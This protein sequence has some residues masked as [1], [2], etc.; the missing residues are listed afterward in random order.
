[1]LAWLDIETTGLDP[2]KES[3]LE[4]GFVVTDDFLVEKAR[5]AW[6]LPFRGQVSDFIRDMH[7]PN[8]L[9]AECAALAAA[10]ELTT[11]PRTSWQI[12]DEVSAFLTEHVGDLSAAPGE[13]PG[14]KPPICGASVDFDRGFLRA[15]P[16][17][18]LLS[19]FSY[20]VID[21]STVKELAR[22]WAP[23]VYES[24]PKPDAHHRVLPDLDTT[25]DEMKHYRQAFFNH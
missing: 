16:F 10:N 3:I 25:L 20:R 1:M 23:G 18:S 21:V 24:R 17:I 7:T 8:G 19:F 6:V 22:R 13:K 2:F 4:I 9:L 15:S 5:R 14:D 12:R 11:K